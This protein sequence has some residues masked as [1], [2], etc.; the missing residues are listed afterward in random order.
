MSDPY[1]EAFEDVLR[2]EAE[3]RKAERKALKERIEIDHLIRSRMT[4]PAGREVIT[5]DISAYT[6]PTDVDRIMDA[7]KERIKRY[8]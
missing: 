1:Q 5:I 3:H 4:T 6:T 8:G 2:Q 7:V